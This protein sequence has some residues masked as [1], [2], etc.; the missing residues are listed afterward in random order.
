MS[1]ELMMRK[2]K[3]VQA[4]NPGDV[5]VI[6]QRDGLCSV[7]QVIEL[8][9]KNVVSCAFYD[10]RMS[11]DKAVGPFELH[12]RHLIAALSVSREQLDFAKWKVVAHQPVV[13]DHELWP[14]EEFRAERWIGAKIYDASIVEKLLNAYN[15]LMPWDDWYD[16]EYL[17][18]L[19]ASPEKKPKHIVYKKKH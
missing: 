7:G 10:I 6:E 5:F 16:P 9:L 13:V 19:L 4:W 8:I 17:D 15:G 12:I 18:K 11:C 1:T 14:N 2:M 3:Q